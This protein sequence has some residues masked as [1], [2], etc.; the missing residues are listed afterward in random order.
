M[1]LIRRAGKLKWIARLHFWVMFFSF[2]LYLGLGFSLGFEFLYQD[3][4]QKFFAFADDT[5][6]VTATVPGPPTVPALT[7]TPVCVAS[8][9]RIVLNWGDDTGTT[10]WNVDRDSLLLTTGLVVSQY[11]DAAV[12]ANTSYSYQVTAF[13]PMSPGTALSAVVSATTLDCTSIVPVTV[14]I[15]TLGGKNVTLGNRQNTDLSKR[16]PK[17]T[18]TTNTPNAI[19][20]IT[21]TNP[22]IRARTLA[23]ANGYFEWIPPIKLD[24]GN[25]I[26]TVTATDPADSSRTGSDSLTF[27]TKNT[28]AAEKS[29]EAA[30]IA[31]GSDTGDF[32]FTITVKNTDDE[33][34]QEEVLI[35]EITPN[36]GVFPEGAFGRIFLNDATRQDILHLPE[37]GLLSGM[38]GLTIETPLPV[39]LA[40]GEYR[41]RADITVDGETVSRED[42]LRLKGLPF[43]S[44]GSRTISYSEAASYIGIIFFSLFFSFL[45]TLLF[46]VREYWLYLHSLHHVTARHLARLGLFGTRKGVIR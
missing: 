20:D 9:P 38:A 6:V 3:I 21:L 36:Q 18:G 22:A 31:G 13:G 2:F 26:L 8:A 23:N 37:T 1:V 35:A 30:V 7:A 43:I 14:V 19:I 42:T 16:R 25:H 4:R 40:P 44:L 33:L 27:W 11:T 10:S 29:R 28:S 46:F 12:T 15:E 39:Y 45:F 17:V 5:I 41:I 24:T 34:F 32:D